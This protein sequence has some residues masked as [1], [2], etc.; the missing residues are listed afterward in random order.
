MHHDIK[1]HNILIDRDG[2]PAG[3]IGV[4][5]C[6]Y[7][8]AAG[9]ALSFGLGSLLTSLVEGARVSY[10]AE[11]IMLAIASASLIGVIFGFMPAR[12]AA[13]ATRPKA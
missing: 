7:G 6:W 5:A 12:S 4:A 13:S 9:V 2:F 8:G 10:S 11:S 3:G 1:P